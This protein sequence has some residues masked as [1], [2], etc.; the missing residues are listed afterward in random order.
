MLRHFLLT[1]RIVTILNNIRRRKWK[2]ITFCLSLACKW[3]W[4]CVYHTFFLIFHVVFMLALKQATWFT[5]CRF[6]FCTISWPS[7]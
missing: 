4:M 2:N 3:F 7:V 6:M 1:I 5:C